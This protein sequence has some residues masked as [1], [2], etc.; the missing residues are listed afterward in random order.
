MRTHT[1]VTA[2]RTVVSSPNSLP[3]VYFLFVSNRLFLCS[4]FE[5]CSPCQQ[6]SGTTLESCV[7]EVKQ[8]K[9]PK[10]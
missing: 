5:V 2:E 4:A 8:R 3:K 10:A 6:C 1:K 9:V 7:S